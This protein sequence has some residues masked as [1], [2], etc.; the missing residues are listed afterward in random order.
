MS[1]RKAPPTKELPK[2]HKELEGFDIEINSF[3]EIKTSINVDRLN[4]FL[5]KH[6]DDKKLRGRDLPDKAEE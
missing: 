6:M 1:K 5:N 2:V 3:G 4:E